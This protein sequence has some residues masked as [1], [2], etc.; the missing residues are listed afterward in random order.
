MRP[1]AVEFGAWEQNAE[2]NIG[3]KREEA[4]EDTG[5]LHI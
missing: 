4:T 5:K 3:P 2:E 1:Y